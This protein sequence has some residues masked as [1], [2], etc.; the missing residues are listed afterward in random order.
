VNAIRTFAI[1]SLVCASA[2]CDQGSGGNQ[3]SHR[4]PSIE[5]QRLASRDPILRSYS[6]LLRAAYNLESCDRDGDPRVVAV[7]RRRK[8]AEAVAKSKDLTPAMALSE[9]VVLFHMQSELH[10]KC[11][12]DFA[13]ALAV[14]ETTVEDFREQVQRPH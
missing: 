9:R 13:A 11:Q 12:P 6:Q 5:E 7:E 2:A 4:V 1:F 14:M 10:A 3:T 8:Q